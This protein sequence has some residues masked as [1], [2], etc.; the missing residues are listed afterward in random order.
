MDV[1]LY[2][3]LVSTTPAI[4]NVTCT[5]AN[6]EY[7]QVLPSNT[8]KIIMNVVNG[9]SSNIIRLA[10]TT[11]KVATPTAP[12]IQYTQDIQY[13]VEG[14]LYNGSIYFASTLAGVTIQIECWS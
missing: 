14:I 2:N 10:Y 8:K 13:V 7:S 12:Y 1:L 4:F 11:G 6:T 3:A 5:N 9:N